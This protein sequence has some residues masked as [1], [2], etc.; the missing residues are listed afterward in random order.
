MAGVEVCVVAG[1]ASQKGGDTPT[2]WLGTHVDIDGKALTGDEVVALKNERRNVGARAR[3]VVNAYVAVDEVI[4][5]FEDRPVARHAGSNERLSTPGRT[6][7]TVVDGEMRSG[8][9]I[10]VDQA[11]HGCVEG[12][13]ENLHVGA[14]LDD[15]IG[16]TSSGDRSV[17]EAG[18]PVQPT[19]V[20]VVLRP[21]HPAEVNSARDV[22][23]R[24]RAADVEDRVGLRGR[25]V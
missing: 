4:A 21:T 14:R 19:E 1:V 22:G 7:V 17:D 16:D 3:S 25:R 5:Y 18:L 24:D 15:R 23:H 12:Q 10:P 9:G 8:D 2:V 13:A 20:D 11:T 6:R